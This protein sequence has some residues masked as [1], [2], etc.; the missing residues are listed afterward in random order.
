MST[1]NK[2]IFI[3]AGLLI[4]L[5]VISFLV[6]PHQ[7]I[8]PAA[9]KDG[10]DRSVEFTQPAQ[11]IISLAPSNTELLF[12]IGAGKQVIG[13]DSFSDYPAE[14]A[15]LPDLGGSMGNFNLEQIAAMQPD[16]ILLAEIN[17]PE[18]IQSFENLG[19]RVFYLSNPGDL[20]GLYANLETVGQLTGHIKEAKALSAQL[21]A[22]VEKVE[23]A[24]QKAETQPLVFYEIDGSSDPAKPWTTGPGTFMDSLIR[25]AGGVNAAG[26]LDSAWAQISQED[27]I[28]KNPD[29]ILLG[30]A[31]Y[32]VSAEMVK[33]RP[34]WNSIK[35][36]QEDKI[37][38]FD[39]NLV[40]RPGPRLIDGLELLLKTIH[41]E[42]NP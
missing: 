31:A 36:V 41:P 40:S 28:V 24:V 4:L 38:A 29:I 37:F 10:L 33:A 14:A 5:S 16:L 26:N 7:S 22:R 18:L 20:P 6:L 27:L 8:V 17:S 15:A 32:G 9:I 34:G 42:L 35:A 30:D 13:R 12:A 19:L 3:I 2:R 1:R 23:A 11:K 25:Q 39:D 21:Q